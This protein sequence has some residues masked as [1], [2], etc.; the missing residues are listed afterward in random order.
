MEYEPP[1]PVT[2]SEIGDYVYDPQV[3]RIA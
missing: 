3:W 1:E 2:A